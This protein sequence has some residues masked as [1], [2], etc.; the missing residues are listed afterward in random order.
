MTKSEPLEFSLYE[1]LPL[2]DLVLYSIFSL[3]DQSIE[4]SFENIA[5]EC[6]ELFPKKFSLQS[7]PEY[8]DPNRVRREIKRMD[9]RGFTPGDQQLIEGNLK[10]TYKISNNGLKKLSQIQNL[11]KTGKIEKKSIER[12][13]KDT[14]GKIGRVLAEIEKHPLYKKFLTDGENTIISE[15]LFRD[16][17]FATMETSDEKLRTNMKT[18]IDYCDAANRNDIKSFLLL[19]CKKFN[20]FF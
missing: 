10:T 12:K 18:L 4:T 5:V 6:F 3:H 19:I 11:L 14:R 7:Y 16:L 13:I 9:G 8:P 20:K 1:Q 17:L 2:S 15:P